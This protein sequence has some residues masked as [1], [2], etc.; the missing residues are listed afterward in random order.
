MAVPYPRLALV[1]PACTG[2]G[3]CLAPCR[4]RAVTLET[5]HPGGFGARRA[6]VDPARCTGCGD[7]VPACPH[8]ALGLTR[9]TRP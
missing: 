2:C 5:E 8:A 1:L 9:L 3:A 7:C 6:V 4:P